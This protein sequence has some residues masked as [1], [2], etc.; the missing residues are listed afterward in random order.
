MGDVVELQAMCCP[1]VMVVTG[2]LMEPIKNAITGIIH[3]TG[4]LWYF[5]GLIEADGLALPVYAGPSYDEALVEAR[6]EGELARAPV[7]IRVQQ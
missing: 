4:E 2:R 1:R 5:V 3:P 6:R 7:F